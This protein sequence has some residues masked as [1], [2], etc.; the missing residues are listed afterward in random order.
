MPSGVAAQTFLVM[1]SDEKKKNREANSLELDQSRQQLVNRTEGLRSCFE[2]ILR[3]NR[4]CMAMSLAPELDEDDLA[5]LG[6][7]LSLQ[8]LITEAAYAQFRLNV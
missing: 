3:L 6:E 2:T 8:R 1:H 7:V 4:A 5:A